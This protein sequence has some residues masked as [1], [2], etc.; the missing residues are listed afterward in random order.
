MRKRPLQCARQ[1]AQRPLRKLRATRFGNRPLCKAVYA[2]HF[3]RNPLCKALR[4]KRFAHSSFAQS[5]LLKGGKGLREALCA[6]PFAQSVLRTC[7]CT[8]SI[9]QNALREALCAKHLAQSALRKALCATRFAHSP[10]RP[11]CLNYS[12]L[13]VLLLVL[14]C[15]EGHSSLPVLFCSRLGSILSVQVFSQSVLF[16]CG[17]GSVLA[18]VLFAQSC[19]YFFF[20]IQFGPVLFSFDPGLKIL[21]RFEFPSISFLVWR[22]RLSQPLDRSIARSLNRITCAALLGAMLLPRLTE[23]IL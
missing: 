12:Y 18:W 7:L 16:C 1:F 4:A 2:K 23:S 14:P 13:S 19:L 3:A 9:S 5:A 22:A 20:L 6:K 8:T 15:Q 10:V 17:L 11:R 21:L